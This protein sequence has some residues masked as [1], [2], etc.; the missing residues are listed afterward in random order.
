MGFVIKALDEDPGELNSIPGPATDLLC[1]LGL[2]LF[3]PLFP[4]CRRWISITD[5]LT[6][7]S[8]SSAGKGLCITACMDNICH[9]EDEIGAAP[10]AALPLQTHSGSD[11]LGPFTGQHHRH[12]HGSHVCTQGT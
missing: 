5:S 4:I 11:E 12:P 6:V 8:A 9:N 10:P 7:S 1:D 2:N 3:V